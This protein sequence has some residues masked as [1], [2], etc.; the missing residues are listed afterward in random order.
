MNMKKYFVIA[1]SALVAL[2]ACN[3]VTPDFEAPDQEVNF[4][5]AKHVAGTKADN[6]SAFSQY[7]TFGTFAIATDGNYDE[8]TEPKV[9]FMDNQEIKFFPGENVWKAA[10][11]TYYW[12]KANKLS[13]ISYAPFTTAAPEDGRFNKLPVFNPESKLFTVTNYTVKSD[14][15][16]QKQDV[17]DEG[18]DVNDLMYSTLVYNKTANETEYGISGNNNG[19]PT[20]F[21]HMLSKVNVNVQVASVADNSMYTYGV[22]VKSLK[23]DNINH[24]GTYS[25]SNVDAGVIGTWS[26]IGDKVSPSLYSDASATLAIGTAFDG[27]ASNQIMTTPKTLVKEYYVMPQSFKGIDDATIVIT[28]DLYTL[29]DGKVYSVDKITEAVEGGKYSIVKLNAMKSGS[30]VKDEWVENTIMTYNITISPGEQVLF[31][32]A[33]SDWDVDNAGYQIVVPLQNS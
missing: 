11:K 27:T 16:I 2:A 5:V 26:P 21:H 22:I 7:E 31:D 19:V 4:Q 6:I 30:T 15:N 10:D 29:K 28:Y 17:L 18:Y 25:N 23:F 3:K 12:P 9:V 13:F 8:T 14:I 33:V 20:L 32:P 1:A 24:Q